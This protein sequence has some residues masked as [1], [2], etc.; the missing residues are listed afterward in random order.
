MR[1]FLTSENMKAMDFPFLE[2]IYYLTPNL[3]Q[4]SLIAVART[5]ENTQVILW[6][7]PDTLSGLLLHPVDNSSALLNPHDDITKALIEVPLRNPRIFRNTGNPQL[8]AFFNELSDMEMYFGSHFSA[9][10]DGR[11]NIQLID[12]VN[13]IRDR[14][15]N[16]SKYYAETLEARILG[17]DQGIFYLSS[18]E[19][20]H[21]SMSRSGIG[22]TLRAGIS[23]RI[24]RIDFPVQAFVPAIDHGEVVGTTVQAFERD[25]PRIIPET[26]YILFRFK[27]GFKLDGYPIWGMQFLGGNSDNCRWF[28]RYGESVG[29]AD[30]YFKHRNS[31]SL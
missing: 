24:L 19:R 9:E 29:R 23:Y 18:P 26:E 27:E 17:D 2:H 15:E 28:Y 14:E 4:I 6:Y 25:Q 16:A 21:G 5:F 8:D 30:V 1:F 12:G 11:V 3:L 22:F 13:K 10:K 7:R 20:N 31:T